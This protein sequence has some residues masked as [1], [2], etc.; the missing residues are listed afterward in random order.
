MY[1]SECFDVTI[2]SI[3][4]FECD[5][6]D[7]DDDLYVHPKTVLCC[8]SIFNSNGKNNGCFNNHHKSPNGKTLLP[9]LFCA[10]PK[11]HDAVMTFCIENLSIMSADFLHKYLVSVCLPALLKKDKQRLAIVT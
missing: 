8:Y 2:Q 10:N 9:M 6:D 5:I 4:S 1:N 7:N 11:I 3:H